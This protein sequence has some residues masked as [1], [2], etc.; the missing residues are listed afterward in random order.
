VLKSRTLQILLKGGTTFDRGDVSA[1][2]LHPVDT[3]GE[4]VEYFCGPPKHC[5]IPRTNSTKLKRRGSR[6]RSPGLRRRPRGYRE[7]RALPGRRRGGGA[8]SRHR[9]RPPSGRVGVPPDEGPSLGPG[10]AQEDRRGKVD[11]T[12]H[13]RFPRFDCRLSHGGPVKGAAEEDSSCRRRRGRGTI[14][15]PR[16]TSTHLASMLT[17]RRNEWRPSPSGA[18]RRTEPHVR[19]ATSC[20]AADH[21]RPPRLLLGPGLGKGRC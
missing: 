15:S 18:S 11:P 14:A 7:E 1:F 17:P 21:Q 16:A 10:E 3:G 9:R 6:R 20:A 2:V 4:K 5:S 19:P 12:T 8:P 13:V